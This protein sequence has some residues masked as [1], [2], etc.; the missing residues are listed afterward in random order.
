MPSRTATESGRKI[1]VI[2]AGFTGTLLALKLVALRPDW[3]IFLIDPC[4]QAGRGTAYGA[5][6][7]QHL[8]NVPAA[9]MEVGLKPDFVTWLGARRG[10]LGEAL[11]EAGGVLADAFV[12]RA[13][14]GAYMEE[15]LNDHAR[16]GDIRRIRAEVVNVTARRIELAD[17][18]AIA[19][20]TVILATGNLPARLPLTAAASARI[21]TDPWADSALAAITTEDSV[22]LLGTGLTMLDMLAI[23]RGRGH[24]GPIHAVS[25]HGYLPHTHHAGG[26]WPA[27]QETALSP[28]EALRAVR[29]AVQSAEA[30]NVPW[31]RVFDALRPRV[32][33]L[34]SGWSIGQRAQ[35]LRHLRARW[36]VHRHR[37]TER[38]A[39]LIDELLWDGTL[40]VTA[41]RV[42]A[43][44]DHQ[45]GVTVLIRPRGG[46]A[47]AV[48]V[49]A[50]I[51]CTGPT[52]DVRRA[53]HR[54]LSNLLQAGLVRSDPLG[55]GLETLDA[56]VIDNDGVPSDWLFALGP[57]TRPAWWEIVA[58]PEITVQ[59]DRLTNRLAYDIRKTAK[60]MSVA[61]LDI[62]AGI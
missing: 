16:P 19:A 42:L 47:L 12:P 36:D 17:G 61:F 20:D 35:F 14:F 30:Q 7:P 25:R 10:D 57:L 44:D 26:S 39:R 56:A 27:F 48:E 32:A 9:R 28:R 60:P 5:C 50:V 58:V 51:N 34:W 45:D 22:L 59:V 38:V 11:A 24:R 37:V 33:G 29:Q 31:Q 49:D 1:G 53:G 54:L 46:R 55:L 13:L 52:L 62:G 18:T 2:G 8:L 15:R 41:G 40:T 43:I 21:V 6:G 3:A 23:L 4:A